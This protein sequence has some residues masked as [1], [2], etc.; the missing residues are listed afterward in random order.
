MTYHAFYQ[1]AYRLFTSTTPLPVDCGKL[2]SGACCQSDDPEAGM[3]LFPEEEALFS[4]PPAGMQVEE[5]CFCS[6]AGH[7]VPILLCQPY[8]DRR[9]RP[10]ACRIFPLFPYLTP[11]GELS[12]RM[13]P[14][15]RGICPLAGVM[16]VSD[17][18]PAFVSKV[19]YLGKLLVRLPV[20]RQ[21][22]YDLS[23]LIDETI[24]F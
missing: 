23:R 11:A 21:Y 15:G 24:L 1:M 6:P 8:C 22:L 7:P 10:L 16:S 5:S 12:V 4:P 18:D 20:M 13:D 2:C 17:L 14:R 3:Y 19:R 9:F